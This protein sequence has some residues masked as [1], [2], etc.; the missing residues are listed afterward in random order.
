M[1]RNYWR[2]TLKGKE[3]FLPHFSV[4]LNAGNGLFQFFQ[5]NAFLLRILCARHHA[6]PRER[7]NKTEGSLPSRSE[8]FSGKDR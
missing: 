8:Y 2:G 1:N 4:C 5:I 3:T 7:M 6:G